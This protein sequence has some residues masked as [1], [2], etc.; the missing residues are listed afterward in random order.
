MGWVVLA[1]IFGAVMILVSRL[2][3]SR[4]EGAPSGAQAAPPPPIGD[5]DDPGGDGDGDGGDGGE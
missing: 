5:I 4:G 1:A 2:T 3:G